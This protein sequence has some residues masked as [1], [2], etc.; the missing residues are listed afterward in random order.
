[1]KDKNIKKGIIGC[2]KN[3]HSIWIGGGL[4]YSINT[5]YEVWLTNET[6]FYGTATEASIGVLGVRCFIFL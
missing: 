1:M 6:A 2:V 5:Y 3:L 4:L